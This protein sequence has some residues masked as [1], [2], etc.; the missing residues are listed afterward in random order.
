MQTLLGHIERWL[1]YS[2]APLEDCAGEKE[3]NG[4]AQSD[5]PVGTKKCTTC[6]EVK[7]LTDYYEEKRRK[8]PRSACK[9]CFYKKAVEYV[10][11]ERGYLNVKYQMMTRKRT[12]LEKR[13]TNKC[14]F[15]FD[16]LLAA[17]EK[18]KS[19]YGMKSAWGPGPDHLE[20]HL[21]V[22]MVLPRN[23]DKKAKRIRSNLSIDRLDNNL[24]YTIQNIIFI[25]GDENVRKRDTTYEDCKIQIRL[26]E[27]RFKNEME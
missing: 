6:G 2:Q 20:Q 21:P 17:W 4:L 19:I 13:R 10:N 23:S 1:A 11:A 15:T 3:V 12:N 14:F 16:E 18:H 27:E 8:T 24:D 25:R 5:K 26:Y 9:D 22:T 7:S